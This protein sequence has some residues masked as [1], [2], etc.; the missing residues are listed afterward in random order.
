MDN[1]DAWSLDQTAGLRLAE[2]L[3][4]GGTAFFSQM[5]SGF[6]EFLATTITGKVEVEG[7][8]PPW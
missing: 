7:V 5:L 3:L 2:V 1:G 4:F 8:G 6:G